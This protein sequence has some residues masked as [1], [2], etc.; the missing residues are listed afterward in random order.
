MILKLLFALEARGWHLSWST[1]S[2][3]QRNY[4]TYA[5]TGGQNTLVCSLLLVKTGKE[6]KKTKLL[7]I[8]P[9]FLVILQRK[10][11]QYL[12]I[13]TLEPENLYFYEPYTQIS[14]LKNIICNC[15]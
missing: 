1:G 9:E 13:I 2:K 14:F 4:V 11:D 6:K 7:H 3:C 10:T 5:D 12:L 8:I 15:A